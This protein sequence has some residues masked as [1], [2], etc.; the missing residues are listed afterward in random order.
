MPKLYSLKYFK[1]NEK[2][3]YYFYLSIYYILSPL[4]LCLPTASNRFNLLYLATVQITNLPLGSNFN[5]IFF[6]TTLNQPMID[7]A[8]QFV[9]TFA[10][11]SYSQF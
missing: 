8:Y 10:S 3:Y 2:S 4:E 7:S 6:N 5:K 11:L 1:Q 9:T